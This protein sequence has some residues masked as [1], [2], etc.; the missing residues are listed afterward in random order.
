MSEFENN[1]YF[2]QKLDAL[3]LS[4]DYKTIYKKGEVIPEY[5]SLPFP[6]DFGIMVNI[7]SDSQFN[8]QVFK[9]KKNNKIDS[10]IVVVNL[11]TRNV[12]VVA[13]VGTDEELKEKILN[14]L[15]QNDYRKTIILKRNNKDVPN[16]AIVD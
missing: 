8:M 11:L 10:I 3:Y 5:S 12:N 9:G 6:C 14:F 4:C 1:A 16:W 2:W 7:N 15:N 13:L